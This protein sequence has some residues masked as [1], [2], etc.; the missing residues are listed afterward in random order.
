MA[1][2]GRILPRAYELAGHDGWGWLPQ[3]NADGN[4]GHE[5]AQADRV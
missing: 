3:G 4:Q 2:L 5:P 1:R